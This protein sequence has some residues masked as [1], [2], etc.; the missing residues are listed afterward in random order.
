LSLQP[1]HSTHSLPNHR[2]RATMA[3]LR[4]P[5]STQSRL[6]PPTPGGS[7]IPTTCPLKPSAGPAATDLRI[8]HRFP[9]DSH[10]LSFHETADNLFNLL[11]TQGRMALPLL[12]HDF[13]ATVANSL[14]NRRPSNPHRVASG[15]GLSVRAQAQSSPVRGSVGS[16]R[17][18]V[19]R[20]VD[21][22]QGKYSRLA[23][24]HV[25]QFRLTSQRLARIGHWPVPAISLARATSRCSVRSAMGAGR[26]LTARGSTRSGR[27][28]TRCA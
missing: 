17:M 15:S 11:G 8:G 4:P 28:A 18:I 5:A 12:P 20:W 19:P 22:Q 10:D 23:L 16:L 13:T 21:L 3:A 2:L 26:R 6:P 24:G 27:L 9:R 7:S 1:P 25:G 14:A